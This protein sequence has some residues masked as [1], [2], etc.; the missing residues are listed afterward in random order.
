MKDVESYS[1]TAKKN[2]TMQELTRDEL[3]QQQCK[4]IEM[5]FANIDDNGDEIDFGQDTKRQQ[6]E[7]RKSTAHE[8]YLQASRPL[9]A[10]SSC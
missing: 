5:M 3:I 1:K 6:D 7:E 9:F 4:E 8:L 2:D 10:N